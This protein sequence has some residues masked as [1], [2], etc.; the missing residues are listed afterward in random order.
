[1][2]ASADAAEPNR[3]V[4]NLGWDALAQRVA[5]CRACKL[6]ETRNNTVFGVGNR[7]AQ[8]MLVGEGPGE[9]ED[10]QGEPFVG[11]AGQLLTKMLRAIGLSR[12]QVYIA[13]IVKCRPPRNRNPASDEAVA[14]RAYLERQIALIQPQLLVSL[15]GVSANNLLNTTEAVG[16]LRHRIHEYRSNDGQ[17]T[18]PLLVTYH[19]SYYLRSPAE[20]GK[21][22][23][24]LQVI[25]KHLLG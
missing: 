3:E 14:C 20:K 10:K 7:N 1:M 6:C 22:W 13:N 2:P 21:G 16:R 9:D 19:P 5:T 12:D 8:L 17:I 24:D 4:A 15:G 23:Q 11:R 25:R 18:V